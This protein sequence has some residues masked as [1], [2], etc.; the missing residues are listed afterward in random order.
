M[1][2]SLLVGYMD[3][4]PSEWL[5]QPIGAPRSEEFFVEYITEAWKICRT[6]ILVHLGVERIVV[7]VSEVPVDMVFWNGMNL[8]RS[9][10][11]KRNDDQIHGGFCGASKRSL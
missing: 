8:D 4:N 10:D 3:I 11:N 5:C 7:L 6:K 9:K 1:S 2:S